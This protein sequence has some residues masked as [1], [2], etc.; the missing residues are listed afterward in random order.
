MAMDLGLLT[1]VTVFFAGMASFLSPCVL[2]IVPG[3]ISYFSGQQGSDQETQSKHN[4]G[5]I[6]A[7]SCAFVFGFSIVFIAMGASLSLLGQL[8]ISYRYE[9]NIVAGVIVVLAGMSILGLLR[10]PMW[11]Q[12]Y[13]QFQPR[14]KE[15]GLGRALLIGFAFGFG[16]TPCIGPVLAGILM[17]G[18]SSASASEATVLLGV[19]ALGLGVPFI[20]SAYF[21]TPFMQRAAHIRRVGSYVRWFS[22][23]VLIIMGVAM[24]TGEL[25]RFAI[26]VY[27]T[28]PVLGRLG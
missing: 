14:G 5:R 8:F 13:Y 23:L 24:S 1:L 28:F 16:W 3:Y 7:L 9:L 27:N 21:V 15:V 25:S 26:W 18:I 10:L 6:V 17:M 19:Y 22:G 12:Y 20:V 4:R 2:P 11:L